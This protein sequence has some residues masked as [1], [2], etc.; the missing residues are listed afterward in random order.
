MNRSEEAMLLRSYHSIWNYQLNQFHVKEKIIRKLKLL[1]KY[2]NK[3]LKTYNDIPDTDI[4]ITYC[5]HQS[6]KSI[7]IKQQRNLL[8]IVGKNN[9]MIGILNQLI[10]Q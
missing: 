5:Y 9:E 4:N 10:Y 1:I 6:C 3:L 7:W 2:I 8:I